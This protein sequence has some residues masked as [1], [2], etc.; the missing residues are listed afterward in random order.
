MLV[1]PNSYDFHQ[2]NLIGQALFLFTKLLP[3]SVMLTIFSVLTYILWADTAY[4]Y[5]EGLL[6]GLVVSK[7]LHFFLTVLPL[8]LVLA[9][10]A[11]Y[12][13]SNAYELYKTGKNS[14][15]KSLI[16]GTLKIALGN[17]LYL[18]FPW[19]LVTFSIYYSPF[20]HNYLPILLWVVSVPIYLIVFQRSSFSFAL[21]GERL[22]SI[23]K[24]ASA[25]HYVILLLTLV[26]IE[27]AA[28]PIHFFEDQFNAGNSIGFVGFLVLH[29]FLAIS[30]GSIVAAV[31]YHDLS[32]NISS[33][34]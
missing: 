5:L 3:L 14:S 18:A 7:A 32:A 23:Y 2:M 16:G 15:N 4:P 21:V 6:R 22:R 9:F 24:K 12:I 30:L 20:H 8:V 28:L 26:V 31:L 13:F 34:E 1:T 27:G 11:T 10:C 17:F 33:G 29:I 19:G 25:S